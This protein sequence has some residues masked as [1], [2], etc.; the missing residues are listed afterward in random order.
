MAMGKAD[1]RVQRDHPK[2]A[3]PERI[4]YS[5]DNGPCA[6]ETRASKI[7]RVWPELSRRVKHA[8]TTHKRVKQSN[9]FVVESNRAAPKTDNSSH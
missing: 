6:N 5:C 9:G 7:N 3:R 4:V 1:Y 8:K 2:N